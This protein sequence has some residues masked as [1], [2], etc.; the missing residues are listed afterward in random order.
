MYADVL[1]FEPLHVELS[2]EVQSHKGVGHGDSTWWFSLESL[3]VPRSSVTGLGFLHTA[4]SPL[5]SYCQ[6]PCQRCASRH[7]LSLRFI[8]HPQSPHQTTHTNQ[9]TLHAPDFSII[10]HTVHSCCSMTSVTALNRPLLELVYSTD[11]VLQSTNRR[12]LKHH[13]WAIALSFKRDRTVSNCSLYR[14]GIA[15]LC[16][17]PT[18]H[19]NAWVTAPNLGLRTYCRRTRGYQPSRMGSCT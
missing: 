18:G 5:L 17:A 10:R 8:E 9:S 13:G 11:A 15:S 7:C 6:F 1:A 2:L 16:R 12:G 4:H 19:C 3:S 14:G